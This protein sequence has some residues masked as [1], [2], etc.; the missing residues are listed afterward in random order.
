MKPCL[1]NA[2]YEEFIQEGMNALVNF[3]RESLA[4]KGLILA[5]VKWTA[6]E[7]CFSW[8][9]TLSINGR[10]AAVTVPE[11]KLIECA[12]NNVESRLDLLRS[13]E[14]MLHRVT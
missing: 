9:L 6:D 4:N 3:L 5:N 13:I 1:H 10:S 2:E 14:D 7:S 12:S 11:Q 8:Q